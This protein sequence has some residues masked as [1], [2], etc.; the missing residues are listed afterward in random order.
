[1]GEPSLGV[2]RRE[3]GRALRYHVPIVASLLALRHGCRPPGLYDSHFG[4]DCRF[5][6]GYSIHNAVYPRE[7]KY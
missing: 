4:R 7:M 6:A 1:M 3:A 5:L 2:L